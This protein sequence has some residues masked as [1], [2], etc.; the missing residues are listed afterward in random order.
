ML[1]PRTHGYKGTGTHRGELYGTIVEGL[2]RFCLV[3]CRAFSITVFLVGG[4]RLSWSGNPEN[5]PVENDLSYRYSYIRLGRSTILRVSRIETKIAG[6]AMDLRY[7]SMAWM[8][9]CY[10]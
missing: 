4:G 5:D 9:S 7:E 3:G 8:V 2:L 10:K 1:C 6:D